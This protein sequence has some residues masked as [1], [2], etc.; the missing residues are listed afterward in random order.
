MIWDYKKTSGS[1]DIQKEF[2]VLFLS[3]LN[4]GFGPILPFAKLL[5]AVKGEGKVTLD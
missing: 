5:G 3:R 4:I 2:S 1:P